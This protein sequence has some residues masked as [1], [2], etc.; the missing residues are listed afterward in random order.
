M[1]RGCDAGAA[2]AQG[3]RAP[4]SRVQKKRMHFARVEV[5]M[6]SSRTSEA[7][8]EAAEGTDT[9][10]AAAG[11][12][13]IEPPP[14]AAAPQP[15][16]ATAYHRYRIA[17][18]PTPDLRPLPHRFQ[19][20]VNRWRLARLL[21]TEVVRYFGRWDVVLNRPCIYGVFSG[22]VGGFRPRP[23]HCVGCLRCTIQ[24]P[25]VVRILPN[26]EL[27]AW[28]DGY[29]TP[30]Q[31]ETLFY[32][33]STG[34]VPVK[35]QGYR[36]RFGGSGWDGMWTDMSEIVRPTRDGI[37]GR[38]LISTVVD[39]GPRLMH[40]DLAADGSLATPPPATLTLQL[41]LLLDPPPP[42]TQSAQAPALAAV[43]ARAAARLESL[44]LLPLD[45]ARR[46]GAAAS[47]AAADLAA[48][49]PV[50]PIVLPGEAGALA[51]LGFRP[52]MVEI[53]GWAPDA[54]AVARRL[55]PE[56]L[57]ALRLR[58]APGWR[59]TLLAACA[60]GVRIV[61]L[62][63]DYH[64]RAERAAAR[65]T[66]AGPAPAGMAATIPTVPTMRTTPATLEAASEPAPAAP[67]QGA[68]PAQGDQ[69]DFILDVLLAANRLLIERG[70]RDQ[71]TL[72]ASGG[73]VAAE[74]VPK[75]I[76]AGA[77]AVAID[78]AALVALQCR[79]LG[80]GAS[81][82]QV[83]FDLPPGLDAAWAVQR[84]LNL[85]AAWRDQ[86]LEVMGA[87]GIRE[88]RRLRGETGRAMFQRDLEA[89]AFAGIEGY[90][91]REPAAQPEAAS[92]HPAAYPAAAGPPPPPGL[93]GAAE[94][95][96]AAGRSAPPAPAR[97]PERAEP[98][99]PLAPPAPAKPS[100]LLAPAGPLAPPAPDALAIPAVT[101]PP[102]PAGALPLVAA[103][104]QEAVLAAGTAGTAGI[105]GTGALGASADVGGAP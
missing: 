13:R 37:H 70:V 62:E 47:A 54:F 53:A 25:E 98:A 12:G 48:A 77:D 16:P 44:A 56:S 23:Q 103:A 58:L 97:L 20:R 61:H 17:T 74:H 64:G 5:T 60:A 79:Q 104:S 83:R 1:L 11:R 18:A 88:V 42:L 8:L 87:M 59:E 6:R 7:T 41:P 80:P 32:E 55:L 15:P 49:P 67:D 76:I 35:G 40:L 73:I 57:V 69:E 31:V 90:P 21:A 81:R 99:G 68:R 39:V 14:P 10:E 43:W 92:P 89:E 65:E 95:L 19:V 29:L 4:L 96:A 105:A 78:T 52:P 51:T 86:L 36:G 28:G 66:A 63:A 93:P 24:H 84:L 27:A 50:V 26:P 2:A 75:A 30:R 34:S 38:E 22:P 45:L 102:S 33:A 3:A 46:A 101:P 94:I 71:V 91:L 100:E 85:G 72:L 9:E 82:Q